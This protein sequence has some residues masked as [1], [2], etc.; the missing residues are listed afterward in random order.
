[1]PIQIA[2]IEDEPAT[3]RNLQ[4]LLQKI[5]NSIE[6]LATLSGVDESIQ[7]LKLNGNKVNLIFA[8]IHLSD[9]TAFHIFQQ[10]SIAKPII[11]VTAYDHYALQAFK[12]NGIDYI[13]KPFDET[14]LANALDKFKQLFSHKGNPSTN[15]SALTSFLQAIQSN[16]LVPTYRQSFLVHFRNKLVPLEASTISWFH[17]E[18][19]VVYASTS[20]NN[21]YVIEQTLE[22][23]EKQLNPIIFFRANRKFIV[24]RKSITEVE[25]YFNGR[26]SL[27]FIPACPELVLISKAR[28]PLFKDWMNT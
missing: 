27:K 4:Y 13:L 17:T 26:L 9:G 6:V 23:L 12:T 25:L 3:A 7:W 28:V 24:Q 14:E 21:Q 16:G 19:E 8:D 10:H 11:F 2:I 15:H 18:N 5:D 22:E 20:D 1:M